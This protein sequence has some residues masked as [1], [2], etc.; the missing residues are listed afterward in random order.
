MQQNVMLQHSTLISKTILRSAT[1]NTGFKY[2]LITPRFSL[3]I[4]PRTI[5]SRFSWSLANQSRKTLSPSPACSTRYFLLA[6]VFCSKLYIFLPSTSI[7]LRNPRLPST[8]SFHPIGFVLCLIDVTR[9]FHIFER[10]FDPGFIALYKTKDGS[11]IDRGMSKGDS[12]E[13]SETA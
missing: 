10:Y 13:D 2:S 11:N 8:L 9:T 1:P 4:F 3:R 7:A 6:F 12:T 5:F